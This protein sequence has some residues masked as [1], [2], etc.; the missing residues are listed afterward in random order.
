[1]K[2]KQ[3]FCSFKNMLRLLEPDKARGLQIE[4]YVIVS[5]CLNF[6]VFSY[7]CRDSLLV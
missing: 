6:G 2:N 1:M 5:N 3:D 7:I 4:A